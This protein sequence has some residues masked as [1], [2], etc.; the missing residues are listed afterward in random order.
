MPTVRL[1]APSVL[2]ALAASAGAQDPRPQPAPELQRAMAK[3]TTH[4][5]RILVVLDAVDGKFAATLKQDRT[6]SRPLLY[7]F[8][9]VSV[10]GEPADVLA[11]SWHLPPARRDKPAIVVLDAD[12]KMLADVPRAALLPDGKLA[13]AALLAQLKPLY[14]APADAEQKLAVAIAEAKKSGRSVFV[15]FDAPW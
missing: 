1:L 9:T 7:E 4:N 2:L 13:S 15:R 5:Q 6:L 3:A 8:E 12:G 11:E 14:C 10:A